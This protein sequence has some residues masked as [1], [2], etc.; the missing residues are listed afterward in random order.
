MSLYGAVGVALAGGLLVALADPLIW[1]WTGRH[2]PDQRLVLA[3]FTLYGVAVSLASPAM[4][5]L[6]SLGRVRIQ[7]LAW[8][9]FAAVSIPIKLIWV[10][11]VDLWRAPLV[12]AC[13][14][15]LVMAATVQID[16]SRILSKGDREDEKPVSG[17]ERSHSSD[18]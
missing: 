5:L 17:G 7:I 14:Y 9:V 1:L 2:F 10:A 8:L 18:P 11:D 15:F 3:A 6:N 4:M 16:V 13:A 12:T